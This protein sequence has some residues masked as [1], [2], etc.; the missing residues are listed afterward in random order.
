MKVWFLDV[1]Y[2]FFDERP[3]LSDDG[4]LWVKKRCS[5]QV[6]EHPFKSQSKKYF[7]MVSNKRN[8]FFFALIV[9]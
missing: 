5:S 2:F 1:Q 3:V 6:E 9:K 7:Y 8:S 4:G